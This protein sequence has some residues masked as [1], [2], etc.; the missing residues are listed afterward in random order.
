MTAGEMTRNATPSDR[1]LDPNQPGNRSRKHP[2][3]D[4]SSSAISDDELPGAPQRKNDEDLSINRQRKHARLQSNDDSS[5]ED[6]P[7]SARSSTWPELGTAAAAAALIAEAGRRRKRLI[8][9]WWQCVSEYPA[10]ALSSESKERLN[11]ANAGFQGS[12]SGLRR[13][14]NVIYADA[15]TV[16]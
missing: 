6:E 10:T 3:D 7:P 5:Q 2:I 9:C 8:R 1:D 11:S 16:W 12:A 4:G 13:V 15:L 14:P